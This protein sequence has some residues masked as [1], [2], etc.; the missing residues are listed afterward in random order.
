MDDFK[1]FMADEGLAENSIKSYCSDIKIF[2]KYYLGSYD[3]PLEEIIHADAITYRNYL[4]AHNYSVNTVN[5]KIA[6]LK[7]YN[8]F[9][10]EKGVQ[11][12]IAINEKD[13]IKKQPST[14]GKDVPT[15]KQLDKLLH[16]ICKAEKNS[17]RDYCLVILLCKGG[18]RESEAVKIRLVDINLDRRLL[19]IF[20][21][22]NKFRQVII[23]DD[24]YYALQEYLEER[25]KI[26]TKNPYLFI[27]QKNIKTTKPLNRIFCNRI[28]NKYNDG[29]D[30]IK[31]LHPHKLRASFCTFALKIAGYDIKEVASQAGHNSLNT[32]KEY[33]GDTDKESLLTKANK[34]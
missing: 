31:D 28:L 9:L 21:K 27:G 15:K 34:L 23:N 13:Y 6:A 2:K 26:D 10:V 4:L 17:K 5:R 11:E 20:G 29:K 7:Q 33:L 22:G 18:L 19:N 8:L 24:M 12:N 16:K 14:L 30:K 32:T 3:E 1:D 25:N